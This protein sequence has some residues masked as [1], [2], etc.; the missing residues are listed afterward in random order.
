MDLS[1]DWP[2]IA[3]FYL[4]E[5]ISG[6]LD[7][8]F[9]R[10][11]GAASSSPSIAVAGGSDDIDARGE[12]CIWQ[13]DGFSGGEDVMHIQQGG[14]WTQCR[15]FDGLRLIDGRV[16]DQGVIIHLVGGRGYHDLL[17]VWDGNIDFPLGGGSV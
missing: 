16:F 17:R 2:S 4:V 11:R 9:C 1:W 14:L 7:A 8:G 15:F 13:A 10:E 3:F 12:Q 5:Q 6:K